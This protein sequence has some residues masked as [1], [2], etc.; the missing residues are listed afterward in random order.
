MFTMRFGPGALARVRF[1]ISPLA[2]LRRS[3]RVLEDPASQ[4]LHLPW[5]LEA[6]L[7]SADLDVAAL[8]ALDPLDV[9]T[10]DF[11]SPPPASPLVE[12]EDELARVAATPIEQVRAEIRRSYRD[13]ELPAV[14]EPLLADTPAALAALVEL[15]RA[16][17]DRALAPH[18]PRLQAVLEGDVLH[19]ARQIADGGAERL[20]A[21]LDPS[22][23]WADGVLRIDKKFESS[24]DLEEPGLLFVPSVFTWPS[25]ALVTD[26]G[27]QP[28]IIYPARGAGM[29][30]EPER[31]AAPEALAGVV[32]RVR[33]AVLITGCSSGIG[34][35]TARRLVERGHVVYASA[36][37]LESIADL[38]AH[39]C[40]LLALDVTDEAS[41][42]AAVRAVEAEHGAVGALINNA[43]YSQSGAIES[44][45]LDEVRR[46]FETNVFGLARMCQLVLPAMRAQRSGRIVNISSIGGTLVFPGGGFYHATKYAVEAI[47]DALRFEVKGFGIKV[48]VIEPGIIRTRF[49]DAVST[50]LP[51]AETAGPYASFNAA[52]EQSTHNAYEEGS[53]VGRLGGEPEAVAK[54]IERAITAKSPKTRYRVTPSARLLIPSRGLMTDKTWDRL[55]STQFPQPGP[56]WGR[57]G[58]CRQPG[59]G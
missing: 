50:A 55:M 33:A 11:V 2:E 58:D 7:S 6:R 54:V 24:L 14:L 53:F 39:G 21:D 8:R 36:R 40:R 23:S 28:T 52:V 26:P 9:Y 18:W 4:A 20:F 5:V 59:S 30:W 57:A 3:R 29:L 41:M 44:V 10:P 22:V 32:G 34:R 1:A 16:Y 47:S 43:G 51:Q 12:F 15:L 42:A 49:A 27:W 31:P 46:Q 25:V 56:E 38:E 35:A 19:R 48:V 37:R 13:R 45:P 17:R